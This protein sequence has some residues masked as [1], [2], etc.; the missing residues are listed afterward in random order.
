GWIDLDLDPLVL[1]L[2]PVV[3]TR[4]ATDRSHHRIETDGHLE[5]VCELHESSVRQAA[6]CDLSLN[7]DTGDDCLGHPT[8]DERVGLRLQREE[9]HAELDDDYRQSSCHTSFRYAQ[10]DAYLHLPLIHRNTW[11]PS[12]LAPV[13]SLT[14]RDDHT[15]RQVS[16]ES[17]SSTSESAIASA[18]GSLWKSIAPNWVRAVSSIASLATNGLIRARSRW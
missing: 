3:P 4:R 6:V 5:V 10:S 18:V 15:A 9:E 8:C 13:S 1:G 11:T 17:S 2:G 14:S 12:V 7:P 16:S